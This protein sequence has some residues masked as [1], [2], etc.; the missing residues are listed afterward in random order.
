M[1]FRH[2]LGKFLVEAG[3]VSEA[4]IEKA[5]EE[6][7]RGGGRLGATLVSLKLCTEEQI[8]TALNDQMGVEVV[9][10]EDVVP[11]PNLQN[12]LSIELIRKYEVIPIKCENRKLWV[13]MMD[14]YNLTAI[15]DIRFKTG[16]SRLVIATCTEG[17]FK[18]YIEEH[19]ETKGLIDEILQ[20]GDFYNKAIEQLEDVELR[21]PGEDEPTSAALLAHELRLASTQS[22]IVTLC[23][24]LLVEAINRR[25]SDIHVEP[26]ATSLRIRLRVDGRLRTIL[27]PPKRLAPA[28]TARLKVMSD[29]DITIRRIPQDGHLAV[30]YQGQVIHFRVSTI[31]TVYGEK[32]VLR[33]LKKDNKLETLHQLGFDPDDIKLFEHCL[34]APFGMILI[35]GPTGSGKTATLHSGLNLISN[36]E[37]NIVT[38]EDPVEATLP[39]I[40]H[41]PVNKRGGMNFADGLRSILRQDPDV[42]FLG[43]IRDTEVATIAMRAAQTGHLVLSTLHTNNAV[44]SIVRLL[45][46][47]I[48]H[49]VI[50]STLLLVMAQ[51]LVRKVC[52]VCAEFVEPTSENLDFLGI[53]PEDSANVIL[54]KGTGCSACMES[55]YRGRTAIY[56]LIKITDEIKELIRKGA[57]SQ[58]LLECAR[59]DGTRS[60]FEAGREKV[61]HGI[62]TIDELKKTLYV[63]ND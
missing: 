58:E 32:S 53:A 27:S 18:R 23:N 37:L 28:I 17:D 26:Y 54:R 46:M 59:V 1:N 60:L 33:L 5:L 43:E 31:P 15:D 4:A 48:P 44:E 55:G 25:A 63:E 62:T 11:D 34:N 57:S 2:K 45:D 3:V 50:T 56:E 40:N 24:F 39:G 36:S 47:G 13:A 9:N 12:L 16:F 38:L 30:N 21:E 10:L 42:I 6:Q 41:I 19:L 29:M 61:L 35:T 20:G 7:R 49:Y 22:P 8:R 51:R 14:P 52:D